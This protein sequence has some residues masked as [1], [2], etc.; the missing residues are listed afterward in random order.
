MAKDIINKMINSSLLNNRQIS[1]ALNNSMQSELMCQKVNDSFKSGESKK[2]T[3]DT[4]LFN[5]KYI[6][7]DDGKCYK[8]GLSMNCEIINKEKQKRNIMKDLIKN[9]I[10]ELEKIKK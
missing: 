3:I 4:P 6:V 1:N 8:I 5:N 7:G 2:F 10:D 9:K